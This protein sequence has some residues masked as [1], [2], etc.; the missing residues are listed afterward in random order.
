MPEIVVDEKFLWE[1]IARSGDKT[2]RLSEAQKELRDKQDKLREQREHRKKKHEMIRGASA[3]SEA[4]HAD[5]DPSVGGETKQQID[6]SKFGSAIEIVAQNTTSNITQESAMEQE[7][8]LLK[9][10]L[11]QT[12]Q[13]MQE[14]ENELHQIQQQLKN[15][16]EYRQQEL[17]NREQEMQAREQA[18]LQEMEAKFTCI[19]NEYAETSARK[20][21]DLVTSMHAQDVK[22]EQVTAQY[23]ELLS[24]KR[25]QEQ[26]LQGLRDADALA[27]KQMREKQE[28]KQ[29]EDEE[30]AAKKSNNNTQNARWHESFNKSIEYAQLTAMKHGFVVLT[31]TARCCET[32]NNLMGH[33]LALDHFGDRIEGALKRGEFS[34][35]IAGFVHDP[36]VME[37]LSNPTFGIAAT[38]LETLSKTHIENIKELERAGAYGYRAKA[39][40]QSSAPASGAAQAQPP[41]HSHASSSSSSTATQQSTSPI[42]KSSDNKNQPQQRHQEATPNPATGWGKRSI[43]RNQQNTQKPHPQMDVSDSDSSDAE[44]EVKIDIDFDINDGNVCYVRDPLTHQTR[45][46]IVN[47]RLGNAFSEQQTNA[48]EVGQEANKY[49]GVMDFMF[50][51]MTTKPLIAPKKPEFSDF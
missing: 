37:V 20:L 10:Q 6:E 29:K 14:R 25:A 48:F 40:N 32:V 39:R 9:T 3:G 44:D 11:T 35:S 13:Q 49:V 46:T 21:E 7:L 38:F 45:K 42:Q 23:E 22:H 15:S 31:T 50:N 24:Q 26:E 16:E 28:K 12:H 27:E 47:E 51:T 17:Q 18:R 43:E 36:V 4:K 34:D 41:E 8:T 5:L 2:M 33:P 19:L 30:E 1:A